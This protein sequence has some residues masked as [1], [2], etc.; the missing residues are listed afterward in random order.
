MSLLQMSFAGGIMIVVIILLRAIWIHQLP[1][2]AF[3]ILWGI[4]LCR[5]LIPY[6]LKSAVS[7]YTFVQKRIPAMT[8]IA[9][10]QP[11][12]PFSA[13]DLEAGHLLM[14]LFSAE[15]LAAGHFSAE[16]L[17]A[18]HFPEEYLAA[19]HFLA[20][21]VAAEYFSAGYLAA[22]HFSA[23]DLPAGQG[24]GDTGVAKATRLVQATQ[25]VQAAVTLPDWMLLRKILW[26]IGAMLC[27]SYY[28]V[29]YIRGYRKFQ[30]S[31]P[32]EQEML[33]EWYMAHELKRKLSVRQSDQIT[34]PLTYGFFH[35]V[36]LMPKASDWDNRRQMSYIL[37]HEY[38]HIQRFDA[39][40]KLI[41]VAAVCIHWFNPLVWVMY[42]LFNRDIELSCDETVIRRFGEHTKAAYATLLVS[43]EEKKSSF[44]PFGS[45]FSK[46]AIEERITAI[47]KI[48]KCSFGL[49]VIA[50]AMIASITAVFATSAA[51]DMR[52]PEE[53]SDTD[54]SDVDYSDADSSDVGY[55]D[56]DYADSDFLDSDYTDMD[57]S[58]ADSS[59]ADSSD[60]DSSD[61]D[62]ADVDYTDMDYG[63][64]D[65]SDVDFSD[66]DSSDVDFSDTDFLDRDF[67]DAEYQKLLAL[68]YDGYEK[69]SVSE[70]QERVWA[71]TDTRMYRDLLDRLAEDEI[72][73][74]LRDTNERSGFLHYTLMPLIDEKWQSHEYSGYTV[75]D[76]PYLDEQARF[77]YTFTLTILD[78][79]K[80]TVGAYEDARVCMCRGL[81]GVLRGKAIEELQDEAEMN[82]YLLQQ[83][84]ALAKQY[85]TDSLKITV[86]DWVYVP[87][88]N[89]PKED[90]E[91]L[92]MSSR[93]MEEDW[94]KTLEPYFPLGLTYEYDSSTSD[95]RMYYQGKEVKS[96][97]D[98]EA[99]IWIAEHAG[100][101]VG[102]YDEDAV[103][104]FAVYENGELV[105]LRA[106]SDQ[107][108]AELSELRNAATAE[109]EARVSCGGFGREEDYRS[110][111]ELKTEQYQEMRLDEFD[112][113]LLDWANEDYDRMERVN[114]DTSTN[115]RQVA[116][117]EEESSFIDL[118]VWASGIENGKFVQS[119]YTGRT[120]E[121]PVLGEYML[122]KT[123]ETDGRTAWCNLY[124]AFSYHIPDKSRITVGERDRCVGGMQSSIQTFWEETSLEELLKME[125]RDI[126]AVLQS[127]AENYSS[128]LMTVS[129][130]AEQIGFEKMDVQA[131]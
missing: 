52:I 71:D 100:S 94:K 34:A 30:Q 120:E 113:R 41:M 108:D 37:E 58:D 67:S 54:S 82:R 86:D 38:I 85:T 13:E 33:E 72:S 6:D 95:V 47:M 110:L 66:T 106:A 20:E 84:D 97:T 40:S 57:C 69:M 129:I 87:V 96:I 15:G 123:A 45:S 49:T 62:S 27:C 126:L 51:S 83:T 104:L 116:L 60:T 43:M 131:Q 78:A 88:V 1:K 76:S 79:D 8:R 93:E 44:V 56:V 109:W 28:M 103:E 29:S 59:D 19:E 7:V 128:N 42:L 63:D 48:K 89:M 107:E 81:N 26:M 46:T 118:T 22:E 105:G 112:Q 18:E 24:H 31:L 75:T 65:F 61:V 36:I 125:E 127:F 25:P 35:P 124:Y 21:D 92:E 99:G 77:E 32:V 55:S 90:A 64:V 117:S 101:G 74:G 130:G 9:E 80:L 4:V 98:E 91:L 102:I 111:L 12:E 39:A 73:Y 70:Y 10:R 121:D 16:Y 115:D 17:A 11:A 114:M 119:S 50:A 68:K 2:K 3:L 14:E 122:D 5:L 23:E 53:I